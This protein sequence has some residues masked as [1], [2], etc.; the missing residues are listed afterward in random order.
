[1]VSGRCQMVLGWGHMVWG[2]CQ[3]VSKMCQKAS[4]RCQM[5]SEGVRWCRDVSYGFGKVSDGEGMV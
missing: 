2:R 4:G 5:L 3:M 1:M